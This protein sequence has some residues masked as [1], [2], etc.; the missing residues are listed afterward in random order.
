MVVLTGSG[1][2]MTL[3][4]ATGPLANGHA[5]HSPALDATMIQWHLVGMFAPSALSALFLKRFG[6]FKTNLGGGFIMAGG[7]AVGIISSSGWAMT[8]TLA[9]VGVGWNVLFVAGSALLLQSYPRPK[10]R[11]AKLQG[12]ADGATAALS[13]AGSFADAGLVQVLG[14][15]GVNVLALTTTAAILVV[16]AALTLRAGRRSTTVDASSPVA[17]GTLDQ[18][19]T[20]RS[21][22][23]GRRPE[24]AI[25]RLG[26]RL[27]SKGGVPDQVCAPKAVCVVTS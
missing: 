23:A 1:L 20:G 10:G 19:S 3:V 22:G 15:S 7:C 8:L 16:L 17:A 26:V 14:W 25:V 27:E 18:E 11:G 24:V 2:V 13:A 21:Q 6:V 5:G 9:L 4:M 12:F